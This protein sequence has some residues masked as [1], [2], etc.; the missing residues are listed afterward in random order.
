MGLWSRASRSHVAHMT[1]GDFYANELS[2]IYQGSHKGSVRIELHTPHDGTVQVLKDSVSLEPNEVFDGT[3]ISVKAL[4]EF[5]ANEIQDAKD[6]DILLSLHL[7]A[8]MMKISGT[9]HSTYRVSFFTTV[10][11]LYNSQFFSYHYC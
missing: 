2:C 9:I 1:S 6:N 11:V 4:Q 8:T 5:Y 3:F 10:V 7:K